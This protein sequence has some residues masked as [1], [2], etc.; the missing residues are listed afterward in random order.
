ME[1]METLV[2]SIGGN[3]LLNPYTSNTKKLSIHNTNINYVSKDIAKLSKN[4]KILLTH[5]N[6]TQIGNE[7]IKN[8][9]SSVERLPLYLINAETQSSIGST[10]ELSLNNRNLKRKFITILTHVVVD[11]KDKAFA[12]P[13][14]PIGLFYN[15]TEFINK[16]KKTDFNYIIKNNKYRIVVPSPLPKNIIEISSIKYMLNNF[17]VICGGGGGIPIIY[18]DKEK[19][20][21]RGIDAVIDKD[22]TTQLIANKINAKR[23]IILTDVDYVY[24]DINN[25]D[26]KISEINIKE[27]NDIINEFEEGTIK[28]KLKACINFI[29]NGGELAQIGNLNKLSDIIN[30][31]SGTLIKR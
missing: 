25:K 26:T 7:L 1:N 2:I 27:L 29:E 4:Y 3:A 11:K 18:K 5:G 12:N 13:T 10:L 21:F 24:R 8:L 30:K 23:M 20:E 14:K 16:F 31:K 6:G 15:K 19:G 9:N 17:N 22:L 28:P